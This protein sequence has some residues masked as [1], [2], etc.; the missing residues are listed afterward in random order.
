[1]RRLRGLLDAL[2]PVGIAGLGVLFFC[3]AFY[4]GA[5]MPADT[6]VKQRTAAAERSRAPLPLQLANADGAAAEVERFY[7]RFPPVEGLNGELNTLY[8]H[9]RASSLQ[10]LQGEY[11]LESKPGA[12]TAYRV[13]LPVR[14][15]YAQVRRFVGTVLKDMPTASVDSLRFERKKAGDAH[16]EAQLRLTIY[17]RPAADGKAI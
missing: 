9:A 5:V 3:I 16:V 4:V 1:M 15:S 14:G 10:L 11:R 8:A 17:L 6:L 12:L 13:T 2:G 7:R